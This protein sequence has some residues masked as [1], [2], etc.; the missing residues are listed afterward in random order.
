MV[1]SWQLSY[2]RVDLT[3]FSGHGNFTKLIFQIQLISK[4]GADCKF[5]VAV[6]TSNSFMTVPEFL[7][8]V[9]LV[10]LHYLP[11][12]VIMTAKPEGKATFLM[13]GYRRSSA[14][15]EKP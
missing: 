5:G 6:E 7:S 10:I 9:P 13:F 14:A 15:L 3:F 8:A 1:A 2:G 12:E 11:R 4:Q